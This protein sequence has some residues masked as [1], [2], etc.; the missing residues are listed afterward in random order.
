MIKRI[1]I[2]GA[3]SIGNHFAHASRSLGWEVHLCDTDPA[4]LERTRTS[5]YP[6]RYGAFD[7]EIQLHVVGNEPKGD[8]DFIL[9]GTPPDAHINLARD[10][11][12]E[13][14]AAVIIEKPLSPPTMDGLIELGDEAATAGVRLFVGYDHVVG[15]AAQ[16]AA[17]QIVSGDIGAIT[18]LTV[19]FREHWQGIFGAHPW[20][21]GPQ[22]TYLGYWKRG[23]GASGEHSHALNL[24]QY[25]AHT[26]GAGRVSEVSAV[27]DYV[28]D[29]QVSYDRLAL[30]SLKCESGLIGHVA[31]DVVTHPPIKAA[32]IQG[33]NGFVS[34]TCGAEPGIDRVEKMVGSGSVEKTDISKTRPD[35]FITELHHI[36]DALDHPDRVSPIDYRFGVDTIR[37]LE[38]AHESATKGVTVK[39]R[40]DD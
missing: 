38:S 14:P 33:V 8:F 16:E 36:L 4:A 5:I 30:F 18:T 2:F 25:F 34:W 1:K 13:K 26:A 37:V 39:V 22:D 21:S 23:G 27:M 15:K 35:D 10:A 17:K 32:R 11:V 7:P 19:S 20:L 28:N 6:Q 40:Y 12:A 3:G 24:W 29:G 9:I 31:Q